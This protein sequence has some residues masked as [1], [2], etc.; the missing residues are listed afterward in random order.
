MARE[1]NHVIE[2]LS[3]IESASTDILNNAEEEKKQYALLMKQK[4]LE[5]DSSLERETQQKLS[6]LK[7]DLENKSTI[8]L[9][10]WREE[11]NANLK[12]IDEKF[13]KFRESRVQQIVDSIVGS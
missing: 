12:Q 9:D 4:T 5:F 10:K 3:K 11:M 1:I 6:K 13:A 8:G 7:E 2:S